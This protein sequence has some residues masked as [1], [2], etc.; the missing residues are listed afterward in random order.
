MRPP[1]SHSHDWGQRRWPRI[2]FLAYLFPPVNTAAAVR[3]WNIAKHLARRGWKVTVVTPHPG[4]WRHAEAAEYVSAA[5]EQEGITR[6]LTDHRWRVLSP[7][8]L[9]CWN[10]TVG[11]LMG[12]LCRRIARRCSLEKEI[13]WNKAVKASCSGIVPGEADM[14]LATGGPFSSFRLARYLSDQLRCPYALDY[15]DSWTN[16]PHVSTSARRRI[17]DEERRLLEGAS[18][19]TTV[20]PSLGDGLN[21]RLQLGPKL[22]VITNGYDREEMEQVRSHAFDHFAIVYA[23]TFYPPKRV[24]TPVMRALSVLNERSTAQRNW[25]FHYY[26]PHGDHV[27]E[28]AQ[29]WDL[30]N[31]VVLHG[32][33]SRSEALSAIAGADV[34]VVITSVKKN[35]T[36]DDR[37]IVTAKIFEAIGLKIPI[38]LVASPKSDA[39]TI[40]KSCGLGARFTADDIEG[41]VV[42]FQECMAG[43]L[44]KGK[45]VEKYAWE[46][47]VLSL[48]SIL[49]Q[50]C[51][52]KKEQAIGRFVGA[53]ANAT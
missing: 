36:P 44:P 3:S 21:N 28:E 34:A 52:L 32:W 53:V 27:R 19:V 38:L 39:E 17:I 14:I 5:L 8:L 1:D 6:I 7:D 30:R 37:G 41:M 51:D 48:D 42:F 16:N 10:T 2:L 31:R 18:V 43:R 4:V 45:C 20:S 50:V 11:W 25:M 15:R 26:G 24:I 46:S 29:R 33:V 47:I 35:G 9:N 12:G 13:G 22:H 23:G 40:I 49:R